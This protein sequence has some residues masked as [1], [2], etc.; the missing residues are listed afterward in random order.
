MAGLKSRGS[1]QFGA[2]MF[3]VSLLPQGGPEQ[4]GAVE[5]RAGFG[6]AAQGL[7]SPR[8]GIRGHPE[9]PSCVRCFGPIGVS[10]R[11]R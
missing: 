2:Q 9:E 3:G 11:P 10:E 7:V 6:G 8:S 4:C 1:V 5:V